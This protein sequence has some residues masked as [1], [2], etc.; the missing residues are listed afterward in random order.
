MEVGR[1]R[2]ALLGFM[3]SA[4]PVILSYLRGRSN[5]ATVVAHAVGVAT[6]T[7]SMKRAE[8][9]ARKRFEKVKPPVQRMRVHSPN[10][11]PSLTLARRPLLDAPILDFRYINVLAVR[12]DSDRVREIDLTRSFA[13]VA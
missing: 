2:D 10:R 13:E 9:I 1:S 8:A 4:L 7:K 12:R 11:Q 5:K 6:T 3:Q